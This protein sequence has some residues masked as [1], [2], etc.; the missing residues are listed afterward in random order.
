MKRHIP[1]I[2]T[3]LN[4][5]CGSAAVILTLWGHFIP[6]FCFM[7]A[8]TLFDLLDG[9]AARLLKS[10]S[11]IGKELDSLSDM[12]SFGLTPALMLFTWYFRENG[13]GPLAFVP[14]LI[15][16]C[17]ALR[18]A[19]FNIKGGESADFRGLPTPACA[20]LIGSTIA[21][22]AMCAG[23]E[24]SSFTVSLLNSKWMIPI[25]SVVLSLL[26]VSEIP[27]VSLKHK[28][29]SFKLS[30]RFMAFLTLALLLCIFSLFQADGSLAGRLLL[31]LQRLF[32]FYIIYNFLLYC[33]RFV[34]K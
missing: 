22:G 18:L 30:P 3:C 32:T 12:V 1:N 28:R 8:A 11:E 6:A 5:V 24:A 15:A 34:N 14:L 25:L 19:K 23:Q 17:S 29:L 2:I 33:L 10:T 20:I 9:A 21:Y 7:L 16:V 31:T 27:M 13:G 4:L 26:L